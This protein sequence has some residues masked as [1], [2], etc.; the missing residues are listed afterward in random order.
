MPPIPRI[1][2]L[3]LCA[4]LAA[5]HAAHAADQG[6]AVVV[7]SATYAKIEW[8]AVADAL[9]KKHDGSL[10]VHT[11][12]VTAC[13]A[14]LASLMPQFT[15]FVA[16][17]QDVGRVFIA[18][19][20]RM[21]RALDGDPYGDTVWGVVS[22][23]TA[24]G[25]LRVAQATEPLAVSSALTLTGVN[26]NLFTQYFGIS[27]GKVGDWVW[28]RPD[29]TV[30]NGADGNADRTALFL[31]HFVAMQPDL[32]VGSGHATEGNL[33]MCFSKGNSIAQDGLWHLVSCTG[34]RTTIPTNAHPRVFLGAGNCLI[35]NFQMR[36]TS[37][38]P[39]MLDAYGFNQFVGYT[40]PTWYGKGGWG[41]LGLW[42]HMP[43]RYS[44]A[45][46]WF[47]NNQVIVHELLAQHPG[48]A[49]TSLPVSESG[50]GISVP[51]VLNLDKDALG[52]L[53]DRD[54]VAFYGDPALRVCLDG[55]R[56]PA[57]VD[58]RFS[59]QAAPGGATNWTLAV[60]IGTNTAGVHADAPLCLWLPRRMHAV[61]TISGR[62]YDPVFAGRFV[63]LM[64]PS[65]ATNSSWSVEFRERLREGKTGDY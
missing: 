11:G 32:L 45:E 20:H 52:L 18:R 33:E 29:G 3:L 47:F 41:T 19:I 51:S 30:T 57:D 65:Y 25:A 31:G 14:Q 58:T 42:Q 39:T 40:V 49:G 56:L 22:A 12:P 46:A 35:G 61:E 63:M 1:F 16:E 37:M 59:P 10:V 34:V 23:A 64:K 28:R 13:R 55:A 24:A 27:D 48:A 4:I 54:V 5:V 15:A 8:R 44:L 21:T 62:Q 9:V 50:E 6:Y 53:W 7:S 43:G 36:P 26:M 38:A 2:P 17:P 60:R